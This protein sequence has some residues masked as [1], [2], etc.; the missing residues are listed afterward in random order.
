MRIHLQYSC[1]DSAGYSSVLG[2]TIVK[3]AMGF[4]MGQVQALTFSNIRQQLNL[5]TDCCQQFTSIHFQVHSTKIFAVRITR[6]GTHIH[7]L[8]LGD[9][10]CLCHH[11]FFTGVTAASQ[12]DGNHIIHQ[13]CIKTVSQKFGVFPHIAVDIHHCLVRVNSSTKDSCSSRRTSASSMV[14]S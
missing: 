13:V 6:V 11:V 8:C 14:T 1:A 4:Y 7:S 5:V 3:G 10:G 12:I 9:P 2:S